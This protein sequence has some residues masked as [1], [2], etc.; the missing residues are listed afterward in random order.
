MTG[1]DDKILEMLS[2]SGAAHNKRSI[3]ITLDRNN[4][5]MSYKTVKRRTPKLAEAGLIEVVDDRG[6]YYMV[7]PLGRQYLK[8][9]ADLSD[10]PEPD[11]GGD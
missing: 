1:S 4:V 3:H 2:D 5:D 11:A 8:E 7:T 10:E 6:P 9:Q